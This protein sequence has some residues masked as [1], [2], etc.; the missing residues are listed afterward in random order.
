MKFRRIISFLLVAMLMI[1][2]VSVAASAFDGDLAATGYYN[3]SYLETYASKAYNETGLGCTYTKAAT[4]FKVWAPEAT[5]V[6]VKL[7]T[8]G[9]DAESG[10]AVKGAHSMTYNSTTGIWSL[11]L[12]GDYK[13]TYY[14]YIVDRKGVIKET[15]D[16]YAKAVGANGDR[17]MVVDLS[18]TDPDGWSADKHVFFDNPG[19]AV[20]WEVHV[21]DF[22]IDVSSGVSDANKGKYLAFTEGNT[23]VNGKGKVAS[24]VDYLVEH[25]VNCVQLMPIEDFASID[26]TDDAVKRNWGYDPKNYN[27]PEGSYSSDPYDGNTR[28]KEF[29]MLVQALHDRGISVVMDVVYN[30]TFVLEGSSL[31]LTTPNYYYRKSSEENYV[32]GSGLGNVLASEKKMCSKFISDSLCYWVNEYHIDGF[33]FDLMGC[34]DVPNMKTWRSNLDKIDK[35]ILMYG[36][37]WG[38]SGEQGISNAINNSN[39]SQLDRVGAFNQGYSDALKGDHDKNTSAQKGFL[40]GSSDTEIKNAASGKST[41]LSG[42]K[43]NQ[44]INYTD[45]HDNLTLFDKILASN[46]TSGYITGKDGKDSAGR[47]L[48]DT[49]KNVVSNPSAQVLSQMKLALTSALT[50]QGIPFTVAGTEFCR[51]KYGDANSYRTPDPVNAIDWNRAEKFTDVASYYAGLMAI[52]KAVDAFTDATANSIT[53]VSGCTA[54]QITNNKSGQWNKVIVALNN[55]SSAKSISISGNWTVVANG[56]KAGTTSLGSASGSYSVPA[57]S[58][59]VLVDSASFGNYNQPNPG[60]ATIVTEHYTRDSASGSYKKIKTETAKYKEGQTW[61]ASKSL[62]ILFDHDFDKVESTASGNATY[63]SV[64]AGA[65]IT[66]KYYYTRYIKSGYLTVN[67]IDTSDGKKVKTPMKYRLRDGDEFSIPATAVQGYE[68]DTTRYPAK[69]R[70]TFDADKPATFNFYYRALTNQTTRVHYYKA[71]T[72]FKNTKT[73]LCYAYDDNGNEPLGDWPSQTK[74][75]AGMKDD[76]SMGTGWVYVDIPATSCYVMFHYG[77]MQVP[78][79]GEKGYTVSGEAW[80]KDGIVSFNNKIVTSHIELATGKQLS[81]DVVKQYTNVSSN[82]IYTTAA[83]SSLGRKYIIPAN[84]SGYYEAGVTNVV[85]LYLAKEEDPGPGPEPPVPGDGNIMGDADLD[86]TVSILDATAIQRHLAEIKTLADSAMA[87]SDVDEDKEVSILDA[88]CI[89]RYLADL[90]TDSVVGKK[91]GGGDEPSDGHTFQEF[92]EVYNQLSSELG[93]YPENKYGSNEYYQAASAAVST[94]RSLTMNPSAAQ[95]DIDKAYDDCKAALEGLANIQGSDPDPDPGEPVTIYFSNNKSW[96][97]VHAYI[98]GDSGQG[99][100]PGEALYAIA[101]NDYGQEIYEVTVSSGDSVIFNGD[102]GQTVDIVVADMTQNAVYCL[103]EADDE[104]HYFYGEWTYSG[105]GNDPGPDP[106]TVTPTGTKMYMS[107]SSEWKQDGARFAAYFFEGASSYVWL[108]MKYAG[109][110]L[111]SVDIP[112]GYSQVI[113]CRMNGASTENNWENKWNQTEDLAVEAGSTYVVEGWGA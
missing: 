3:Q 6:S 55:T 41:F 87:L 35:R 92:V 29:K 44:L 9:T 103:D 75:T 110:N 81:D 99:E 47:S 15:Q 74:A 13:N 4:T 49:N 67:F 50:S 42:S 33:R 94:Y 77:D 108:N 17:S 8:T 83:N 90:P 39:L 24:C 66:V 80:I 88:T 91:V 36:E 63:G 111:Y 109:E 23:T 45:N 58:G 96:G 102:G 82:T 20:V 34:H 64:T 38:G 61:R 30:H 51:T 73:I 60:V 79:Q 57:Y 101:T 105:G 86:G 26:E 78:G 31:N 40:Q 84:A 62:A 70:D 19:E 104:G 7:Y 95:E 28:I 71:N 1:S 46:G 5:G 54:W 16:P 25:N 106:G 32:N 48:Y 89:Q 18:S 59:V 100:W 69:T 72:K 98:W 93:K 112:E 22:S 21:R 27:V 97:D 43:V 76:T 37:P 56:T 85:Y 107:P 14:T 53:N 2:V 12:S 68:V 52:R 10:A 11:T 65:S 113:F